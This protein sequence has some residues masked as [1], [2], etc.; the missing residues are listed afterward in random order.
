M[1][2]GTCG[3]RCIHGKKLIWSIQNLIWSIQAMAFHAE[4]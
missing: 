4:F 2:K 1:T 3:M